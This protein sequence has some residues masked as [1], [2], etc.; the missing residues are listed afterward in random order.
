MQTIKN[1]DLVIQLMIGYHCDKK[2]IYNAFFPSLKFKAFVFVI[3]S[4]KNFHRVKFQSHAC[5]NHIENE[6]RFQSRHSILAPSYINL[7]LGV[8]LE[9]SFSATDTTLLSFSATNCSQPFYWSISI[10]LSSFRLHVLVWYPKS[11]LNSN[12]AA[13]MNLWHGNAFPLHM[14]VTSEKGTQLPLMNEVLRLSPSD[15]VSVM[16]KSKRSF[17]PLAWR[18][19]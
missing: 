7:Q 3:V 18:S 5:F 12:L 2:N 10:Y 11:Q 4:N 14:R 6:T 13:S 19:E 8:E 16:P 17:L 9:H 1:Y 15:G